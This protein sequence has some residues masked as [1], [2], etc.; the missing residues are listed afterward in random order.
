M[1]SLVIGG[2]V[3]GALLAAPHAAADPSGWCEWTPDLDPSQCG[4][5]V[6][7]PA[8]GQLVSEPGDWSTGEVRTK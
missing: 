8:S 1:K 3:I 7:V 6:G 5:I 4:L 2:F